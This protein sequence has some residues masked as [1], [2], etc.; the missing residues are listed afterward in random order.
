[1]RGRAGEREG[2]RERHKE[3]E[4]ER[5]ERERR[6]REWIILHQER[7]NHMPVYLLL[8]LYAPQFNLFLL[9][10]IHRLLRLRFDQGTSDS[11]P[12]HCTLRYTYIPA[13]SLVEKRVLVEKQVCI[14]K[15]HPL[16][17]A[18]PSRSSRGSVLRRARFA[19]QTTEGGRRA[20]GH[21]RKAISHP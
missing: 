20:R 6:G 18:G 16:S 13:I 10:A 9:N 21:L 15:S 7:K 19:P 11:F 5:R 2:D 17:H 1:M 14:V 3:R 8:F 4:R 12:N